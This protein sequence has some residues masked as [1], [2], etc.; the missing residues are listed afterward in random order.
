MLNLIFTPFP[1]IYNTIDTA[2]M[3]SE[4]TFKLKNERNRQFK[5]GENENKAKNGELRHELT[6]FPMLIYSN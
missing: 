5:R 4:P 3:L 6:I 1:F 2:K